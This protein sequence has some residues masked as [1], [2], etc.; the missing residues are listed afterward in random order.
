MPNIS[1]KKIYEL[2]NKLKTRKKRNKKNNIN[3]LATNVTPQQITELC[4]NSETTYEP[5]EHKIEE[6]F[7]RIELK[8]I[9][10]EYTLDNESQI[11]Q[12]AAEGP[13]QYGDEES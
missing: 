3:K 8:P 9:A 6:L 13:V 5:F 11:I 12:N 4:K 10:K 7:N 1:I 2:K